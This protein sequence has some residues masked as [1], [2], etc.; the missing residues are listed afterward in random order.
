MRKNAVVIAVAGALMLG[1]TA[2][3]GAADPK[4]EFVGSEK[5][6]KCHSEEYKSWKET[7]HSKMVR[8]KKGAIL[9]EAVE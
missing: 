4:G 1:L 9:K 2:A 8:P 6:K 3:A 7:W 5:C